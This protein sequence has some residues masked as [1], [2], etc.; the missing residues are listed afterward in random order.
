MHF[1]RYARRTGVY[2]S[3]TKMAIT[4]AK[5]PA[6]TA[7][8]QLVQCQSI[9]G[10]VAMK[11]ATVG[12]TKD[13]KKTNTDRRGKTYVRSRRDLVSYCQMDGTEERIGWDAWTN[14][15]SLQV[16]PNVTAGGLPKKPMKARQMIQVWTFVAAALPKEKHAMPRRLITYTGFLKHS[17]MSNESS[18][19]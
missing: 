9:S 10:L 5:P 18:P 15:R 14:Q 7:V 3:G 16:P 1:A 8:S 19:C 12:V 17:H 11:S 2:V 6:R 13:P 4:S